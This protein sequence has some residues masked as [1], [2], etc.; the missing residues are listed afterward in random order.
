MKFLK[1]FLSFIISLVITLLIMVFSLNLI[2]KNVIEKEILGGV[3]K[4]QIISEYIENADVE[5]KELIKELLDEKEVTTIASNVIDEYME[6]LEDNNHRVS[7]K[8]LNSIIS[9]C[10]KHRTQI[11]KIAGRDIPESEMTSQETYRNLSDSINEGFEH[12]G[13][14]INTSGTEIVKTYNNLTSTNFKIIIIISIIISI[15]L[16]MV[17]KNSLYKWL[18][19][20]GKALITNSIIIIVLYFALT[21]IVDEII[22]QQNIDITIELSGI[23]SIGIVELV[24]GIILIMIKKIIDK[25]IKEKK[26]TVDY[27]SSAET[28]T[29]VSQDE[30][31]TKTESSDIDKIMDSIPQS[32]EKQQTIDNSINNETL[33]DSKNIDNEQ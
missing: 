23:L 11:S 4:D 6:Y 3:V 19:N 8:T 24:L 32:E 30:E 33:D 12:V 31:S 10:V 13:N 27:S 7:E 18:S 28:L 9:F 20:L 1:G 5:N 14:E 26:K 15:I 22:K 16:L 2:F 25:S 29:F 17:I 21:T